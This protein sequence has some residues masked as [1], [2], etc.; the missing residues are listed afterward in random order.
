VKASI[1]SAQLVRP[2]GTIDMQRWG[3]LMGADPSFPILCVIGF[4][5]E[6]ESEGRIEEFLRMGAR[7]ARTFVLGYSKCGINGDDYVS[8]G[9]ATKPGRWKAAVECTGGVPEMSKSPV[10]DRMFTIN[11][12]LW[13]VSSGSPQQIGAV[14]PSMLLGLNAKAHKT[15]DEVWLQMFASPIL[16][17]DAMNYLEL[18]VVLLPD[19]PRCWG[20]IG[21]QCQEKPGRFFFKRV[22]YARESCLQDWTDRDAVESSRGVFG[23]KSTHAG[24][25]EIRMVPEEEVEVGQVLENVFVPRVE[26]KELLGNRFLE[27][28]AVRWTNPSVKSYRFSDLRALM[29]PLMKLIDKKRMWKEYRYAWW[30]EE[31]GFIF[32]RKV[33]LEKGKEMQHASLGFIPQFKRSPFA[34]EGISMRERVRKLWRQVHPVS[35]HDQAEGEEIYQFEDGV[36]GVERDAAFSYGHE[37]PE[38]KGEEI[39]WAKEGII[40]KGPQLRTGLGYGSYTL[41]PWCE[42]GVPSANSAIG[43]R[44]ARQARREKPQRRSFDVDQ[45]DPVDNQLSSYKKNKKLQHYA[46]LVS[47][48]DEM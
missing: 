35:W 6:L 5:I 26:L 22:L 27:H 25:T 43:F 37:E 23:F 1:I 45:A 2:D 38:R 21:T 3:Q 24:A 9:D 40:K 13:S 44:R 46:C 20:G 47:F 30:F 11:S 14:L 28:Q 12:Q 18:D 4:L 15:P 48:S 17:V 31:R 36:G 42:D 19:L 41:Q 7:E 33:R 34:Y 10:N 8:A 29:A 32:A 39:E 16:T